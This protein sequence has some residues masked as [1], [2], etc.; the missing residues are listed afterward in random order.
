MPFCYFSRVH[1]GTSW[2]DLKANEQLQVIRDCK[3]IEYLELISIVV[4]QEEFDLIC[5]DVS[6]ARSCYQKYSHQSIATL[7]GK[8]KCITIKNRY[9]K[10]KIV[11]YTAGRIYPLYAAV[12]EWDYRDTSEMRK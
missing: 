3:K 11:L 12:C 4:D 5:N 2:T 8:W 7:D 1:K 10:Q 6:N 9:R